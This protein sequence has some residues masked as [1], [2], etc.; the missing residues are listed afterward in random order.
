LYTLRN[1]LEESLGIKFE[2]QRGD[3]FFRSTLVQTLFY[4]IFSAWV[5]WSKQH[6]MDSKA[7]F[8]WRSAAWSLHIPMVRELFEQIAIPTKLGPLGISVILDWTE[9]A[10]KRVDRN[11]FFKK[12]EEHQAVQYFYEPFLEAFGQ[13]CL[14][15]V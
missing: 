1:G 9:S 6:I 14:L 12:F 7:S 11:I 2:G 15:A 8:D 4:G 13:Q 5:L 10:L 3:H